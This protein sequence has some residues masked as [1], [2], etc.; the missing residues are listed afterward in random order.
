MTDGMSKFAVVFRIVFGPV[1]ELG[2]SDY[3][4]HLDRI[5]LT[6]RIVLI[7]A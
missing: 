6:N 1:H 7:S 2:K 5:M 3:N 4:A